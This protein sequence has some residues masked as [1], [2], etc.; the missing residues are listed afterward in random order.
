MFKICVIGCGAMSQS[1]HGPSFAKYKKDYRDVV[2]SGCCDLDEN[3]ALAYKEEF[4]FEKHYTDYHAM[5]DEIHPDVVSIISPVDY[6]CPIC[7]DVMKK[8]YSII[9]EKPPGKNREEIELMDKTAKEN[10]VNVRTSFNRRYTPLI[11]ELIRRVRATGEKIINITYQ[12]YRYHRYDKDFSTTSI[13]AVDVVKYIAGSDYKSVDLSYDLHSELGENV[14]NVFMNGTFENGA[15]FQISLV[16]TG[17]A[18]TERVTVNTVGHSFFVDLP[19]WENIDV[20]GKLLQVTENNKCQ[21]VMGDELSD[22]T[23]MFEVSGF[24]DENRLYFEKLRE[25]NERINDLQSAIQSVEL[26]DCI[27]KSIT[28]Y[29]KKSDKAMFDFTKEDFQKFCQ[30]SHMTDDAYYGFERAKELGFKNEDV[31]IAPGAIINCRDKSKIG[32]N[33]RIGLYTY[34]SGDVTIGDNTM[35]GPHCSLPAG[36]HKFDAKTGWFSARTER[37]Y[38][39]SIVIGEGSWLAT[40]VTVTAGVKIGMCNLICAGAVVTK[41]TDDYAIMA[42]I[43][44]KKIGHIDSKTG[45]YI[46][47]KE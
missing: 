12:L 38:D 42:G 8:G 15:H 35:I 40:G 39:N 27:R 25:R 4:G 16:P 7:V 2:L 14:K 3:K 43:P 41:N 5:L 21:V 33:V 31:S 37:D 45:E 11:M 34:I 36:N 30:L 17:G 29:E 26:E 46:Y 20:P 9:L 32:K 23:E 44:A 13:H 28:H 10:G 19:M 47:D 22:T 18:I 6:T 24:Y 1:G